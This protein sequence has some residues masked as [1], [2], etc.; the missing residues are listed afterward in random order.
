MFGS[1]G[2]ETE[3]DIFLS[4][5]MSGWVERNLRNPTRGSF[6]AKRGLINKSIE[7]LCENQRTIL[8]Y[9]HIML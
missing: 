2:L 8:P 1:F 3:D 6:A 7:S 4:L 5:N 9:N